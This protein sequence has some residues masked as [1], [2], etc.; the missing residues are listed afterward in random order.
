MFS[1]EFCEISKNIFFTEH[2]WT[3]A[4]E[5]FTGDIAVKQENFIFCALTVEEL[6]TDKRK[7][8]WSVY[9]FLDY[10][11]NHDSKEKDLRFDMLVS[12]F[13]QDFLH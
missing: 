12:S 6:S 4:S 5:C 8:P 7:E 3:I 1:C 13:A 11:L 2:L 10:L 9:T